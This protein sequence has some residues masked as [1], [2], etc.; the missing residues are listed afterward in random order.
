MALNSPNADKKV[1]GFISE[2]F[3]T[4]EIRKVVGVKLGDS[5]G[6]KDVSPPPKRKGLLV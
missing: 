5:Q 3:R 6:Q 2:K 4:P 1:L